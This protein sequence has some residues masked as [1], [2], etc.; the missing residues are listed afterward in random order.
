MKR[1][2]ALLVIFVVTEL[3]LASCQKMDDRL[4][5]EVATMELPI[6]SPFKSIS[7]YNNLNVTIKHGHNTK[8]KLTCPSKLVDKISYTVSGD[9]LYLRNEN[10]FH[11]N[12][13]TNY[14]CEMT[15]Y[16]DTLCSID[17]ASIGYLKCDL[18]DS[19]RGYKDP[20]TIN[21][22]II[23]D[24]IFTDTITNPEY[25]YF[26]INEGSGDIDLTFSCKLIKVFFNNGTSKVKFSGK[27]NYCDYYL[28]SY[29]QFDA[30]NLKSNYVRI[31]NASPNDAYVWAVK[32]TKNP[33]GLIARIYSRGNIYYKGNP[34]ID[35]VNQGQGRIIPLQED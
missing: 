25:F 22:T 35:F 4:Y 30:R 3:L 17:Y 23:N 8:I 12:F 6:D 16:Y 27:A 34:T 28:R 15:V 26:N 2:H 33:V 31:S 29:G 20:P 1:N 19:I 14:Q 32:D 9:T 24:S 7:I 21:D 18:N 13:S 11:L 5:G 10:A